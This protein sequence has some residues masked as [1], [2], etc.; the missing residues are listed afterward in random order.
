MSGPDL[1][2]PGSHFRKGTLERLRRAKG[3]R[4]RV[5]SLAGV[6][7]LVAAGISLAVVLSPSNGGGFHGPLGSNPKGPGFTSGTG[8]TGTGNTGTGNTEAGS[9]GTGNTGTGNTGT[10]NSSTA[11]AGNGNTGTGNTG[12]ANPSTG[13]TSSGNT[14]TASGSSASGSGVN[15]TIP[16]N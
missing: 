9:T 11:V 6:L 8:N 12:T 14:G 3:Q 2:H 4:A 5:A 13:I 16:G 1:P 7:L 15:A 10:A